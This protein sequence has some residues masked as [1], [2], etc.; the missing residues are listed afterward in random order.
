[1]SGADRARGA[2]R[3]LREAAFGRG[4]C[5][6]GGADARGAGAG[7]KRRDR[8]VRGCEVEAGGLHSGLES[9]GRGLAALLREVEAACEER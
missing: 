1:M 7:R 6:A 4:G 3:V 9:T 5:D 8:A 2:A